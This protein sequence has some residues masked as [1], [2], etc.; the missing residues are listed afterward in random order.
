LD[1]FRQNSIKKISNIEIIIFS[2]WRLNMFSR[3]TSIKSF[4]L[5]IVSVA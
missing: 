4:T 2:W 5:V 1:I 3:V